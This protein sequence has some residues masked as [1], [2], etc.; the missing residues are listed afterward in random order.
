VKAKETKYMSYE[1]KWA[2]LNLEKLER[3]PRTEY[4][5]EMHWELI[6]AV[7]GLKIDE[8][9]SLIAQQQASNAF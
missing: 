4:S 6:E 5:A 2:A 1:E 3:V 8:H 7:T 9:S